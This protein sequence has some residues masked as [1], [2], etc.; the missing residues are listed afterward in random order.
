MLPLVAFHE[1]PL[2]P[3]TS[4]AGTPAA[5]ASMTRLPA[6]SSQWPGSAESIQRMSGSPSPGANRMLKLYE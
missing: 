3:V 2:K 6:N 1:P 5:R 4:R